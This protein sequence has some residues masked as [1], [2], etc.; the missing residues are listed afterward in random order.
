VQVGSRKV[1]WANVNNM[2]THFTESKSPATPEMLHEI[3]QKIGCVLPEQYKAFLLAHNGGRPKPSYFKIQW[4]NQEWAERWDR[5]FIH[6]FLSVSS[7][8]SGKHFDFL[9]YYETFKGRIPEDT[10]AIAYDEGRSLVLLGTGKGNHGKAFFWLGSEEPDED[11]EENTASYCN[12][13]FVA[14]SFNEFMESLC[15]GENQ[16][17]ANTHIVPYANLIEDF[18]ARRTTVLAFEKIYLVLFKNDKTNWSEEEYTA[19]NDLFF[20]VDAYVADPALR[21]QGDLDEQGLKDA[22]KKALYVLQSSNT[23]RG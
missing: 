3:G 15:E 8:K 23:D 6:F 5:D 9:D 16:G 21:E 12:V 4:N 20:A 1:G 17:Y 19:L 14:D 13:G 10:I 2:P 11:D 22:C 7:G 18:L